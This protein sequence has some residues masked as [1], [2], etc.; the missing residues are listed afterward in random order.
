MTDIA[1]TPRAMDAPAFP[2]D[3]TCPYQLPEGYAKL[4]DVPGPL[5]RVTLYDGRQVWVVTKH[6]AAR[7]LLAD[8]RLS[9]RRTDANFPATSPRFEVVREGRPAF[10]GMDPPE[11]GPKR[12]MTISEFTVKRIKGM[13]PE[14]EEIVHGFLD[15]MLAS[16][17]PADLVSQFSLPV[18]SMVI[19][20]LLGVPY[21]DH[22]FFQDASKRLVQATD[23]AS[24]SAARQD[25][26]RYMDA[27]ITACQAEPRPG[28]VST[29]VTE[30]LAKG[31]IDREEL[32]STAMLL[33]IAGHETTASMTSLSAITLLEHPEQ[34]AALRE[35]RSLIPGAVEEL[36]RYLAIA[37]I[38]G[39]R[40]ALA[41]IEI[42]GQ[43][44]RAG[45]GVIVVNSIANRDGSVYEDP[46]SFDVRRSAR[47]HLSFGFGVHQCLG[48]NL[49]RL[50]LEV[51]LNALMDRVPTLKLAV[52]VDQLKLRPGT[53]IQGVNELPV[54]W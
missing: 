39:G 52:P 5:H 7:K 13:R 43:L 42:E 29:L 30:Q 54:T 1:T 35:D 26:V 45:E 14:V 17:P 50:E 2:S 20:R 34:Y 49:A 21:A 47:H 18:P 19:C 46:D 28:L 16:G 9:S 23:V 24:A 32:A 27:L 36:L 3:R 40:I 11:H 37:D 33:L 25:L 31:E 48:Q 12:R 22:D 6:E 8:P 4:R 41:D 53:T 51:I 15:E 38:A 44:I 10:I